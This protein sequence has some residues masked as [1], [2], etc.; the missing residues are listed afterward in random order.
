MNASSANAAAK[1]TRPSRS[2]APTSG[3]ATSRPVLPSAITELFIA[4]ELPLGDEDRLVYR[5]GLLGT[6]RAHFSRVSYKLDTWSDYILVDAFHDGELPDEL[7]STA[8]RF[9][10]T[11]SDIER[12]EKR[13]TFSDMPKK[14]GKAK[15]YKSFGTKMKD[16]IYRTE[17]FLVYRCKSLKAYSTSTETQ[18]DFKLRLKQLLR[19][20]RD[21]AV[22]K[23]RKKHGTALARLKNKIDSAEEKLGREEA[24]YRKSKSDTVISF[25]ESI[26]GA[27]FGRKLRSTT[28]VS[29]ASRSAKGLGRTA[30]ERA[31]VKQAE[32]DLAEA[33]LALKEQSEQFV[34]DVDELAESLQF[35]QLEI[36]EL[37]VRAKK[38]D[39]KVSNVS[40]VWLPWVINTDGE[41]EPAW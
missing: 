24:Q 38:T 23:L 3:E 33:E 40:L 30:K 26:L 25:G 35:D 5:P 9:D 34:Q 4:R 8:M 37:T 32:E 14:L 20:K 41:S 21:A 10:R 36:E 13:A 39:L 7:W 11:P 2:P 6:A 15:S 16:Y 27:I 22:E 17:R 1:T 31:D 18:E 28:N 29:R 19:E 12:P